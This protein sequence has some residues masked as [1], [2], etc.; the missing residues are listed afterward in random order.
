MLR[1]LEN[2][3]IPLCPDYPVTKT[4][5]GFVADYISTGSNYSHE[6]KRL[7]PPGFLWRRRFE[8]FL[9]FIAKLTV[10]FPGEGSICT[11]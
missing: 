5:T 11:S 4:V 10:F 3:I 6:S 7:S 9:P 2:R 8:V 1:A